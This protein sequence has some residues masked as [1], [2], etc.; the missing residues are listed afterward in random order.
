[1]RLSILG[2]EG[3]GTLPVRLGFEV[4]PGDVFVALVLVY[5]LAY[6][7]LLEPIETAAGNKREVRHML[8]AVALPLTVTFL[9]VLTF[10]IFERE[11][12]LFAVGGLG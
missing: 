4:G 5:I 10:T 8:L 9:A 1:M 6:L 7:Y 12:V 2:P 3:S 11:V